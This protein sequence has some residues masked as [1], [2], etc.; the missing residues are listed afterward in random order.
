MAGTNRWLIASLALSLPFFFALADTAIKADRIVVLK[1]K[2]TMHLY[3]G[4]TI[5]KTYKV[6]LGGEPEGAKTRQGDHRTPEGTY[7]IDSKN[8]R[9]QFHLSLH[10]SYPN[11]QDR[12]H[13]RKQGV[14]PGGDIMI[15]GLPP[16]Y[17]FVGATHTTV[18][19]TDGCIA[20]TNSEIEEIWN[21]VPVGTVIEIK[22]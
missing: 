20:V 22:P 19:W 21:L 8:L 15:H 11:P 13:A 1:S 16:R 12:E 14:S 2:R 17:A 18:D 4:E 9:S 10:I 6:A 7:R 3:N 5:L